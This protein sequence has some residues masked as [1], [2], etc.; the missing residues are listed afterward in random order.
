MA[1]TSGTFTRCPLMFLH[2]DS[3][4]LLYGV[5]SRRLLEPSQRSKQRAGAVLIADQ[6]IR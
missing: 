1:R 4:P 3:A 5:D 6:V 2:G